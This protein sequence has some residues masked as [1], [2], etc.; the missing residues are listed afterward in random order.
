MALLGLGVV[1]D[2]IVKRF[3]EDG[4]AEGPRRYLVYGYNMEIC[5]ALGH[6]YVS[7]WRWGYTVG[8]R[9]GRPRADLDLLEHMRDWDE[10]EE[11]RSF[12]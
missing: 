4:W 1:E 2:R 12:V 8:G 6:V 9:A 7:I 3:I 11:R 5:V 10:V